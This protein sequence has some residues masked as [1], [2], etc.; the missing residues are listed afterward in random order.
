MRTCPVKQLLSTDT[1]NFN[2]DKS[3]E[4]PILLSDPST[5]EIISL[6]ILMYVGESQSMAQ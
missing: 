6:K 3:E 1:K 2:D 5:Y 4:T